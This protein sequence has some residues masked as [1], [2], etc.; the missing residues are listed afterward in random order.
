MRVGW[1]VPSL[2]ITLRSNRGVVTSSDLL[3]IADTF[4]LRYRVGKDRVDRLT[5][6]FFAKAFRGE[7]VPQDPNDEP[8]SGCSNAPAL[9]SL[10]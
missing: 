1:F 6:S 5:P 3:S 10:P 8:A 7:L 4:E 2:A 9:P